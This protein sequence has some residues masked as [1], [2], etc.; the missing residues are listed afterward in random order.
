MLSALQATS[1]E[2]LT[3]NPDKVRQLKALGVDVRAQIPTGFHETA[4]NACYL[5]AKVA[6]GHQMDRTGHSA[7]EQRGGAVSPG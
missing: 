7:E 6:S 5:A 2:L 3:N 1:I 4:T